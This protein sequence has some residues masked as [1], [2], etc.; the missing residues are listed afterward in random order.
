[1]TK[2]ILRETFLTSGDIEISELEYFLQ[3][4]N[5]KCRMNHLQERM[6]ST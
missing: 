3:V 4:E 1:M 5:D 2:Q 6:W